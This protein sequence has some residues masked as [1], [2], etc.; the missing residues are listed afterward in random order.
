MLED[1]VDRIYE[2]AFVPDAWPDAFAHLASLS[3]AA[4]SAFVIYNGDEQPRF[5]SLPL[6]EPALH[7]F[8]STDAWKQSM[9]VSSLNTP[10]MFEL[11]HR[12]VCP[13]EFQSPAELDRDPVQGV[14]RSLGMRSQIGTAV[15]MLTGE[16]V[17][18][19]VERWEKDG[20]FP[21]DALARLGVV[22]PHLAR[23]GLMAARLRLERAHT[24]VAVMERL[25]LPAAVLASGGKVL[26]TNALL[27]KLPAVFRARAGG[28]LALPTAEADALLQLASSQ[29]S[30]NVNAPV[31]SIPIPSVSGST[32]I[33]LHVLPLRRA[34]HDIFPGGDILLAATSVAAGARTPSPG[35]L[36]A[37]FDL[38]PAEARLAAALASGKSLKEI[39][40]QQGIQV[41]SA[42]TYLAHIFRKTGTHQQSELVS[43]L[44]SAQP[45]G[46]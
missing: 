21:A 15:T 8:T 24:S 34:A 18:F 20:P 10:M 6:L 45:F 14:L 46:P 2:A 28:G 9:R 3:G 4:S 33:V 25:G 27:E 17:A 42:R 44:K 7:A 29:F 39:A 13:E 22:R 19:S 35:I 31:R 23:A 11:S 36:A 32:P 5:K 16:I 26:A 1:A 40:A 43:L 30:H 37:L 38:A 12:W 41:S